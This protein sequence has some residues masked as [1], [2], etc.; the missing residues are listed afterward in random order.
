[1]KYGE[2]NRLLVTCM[3]ATSVL[4]PL[5]LNANASAQATTVKAAM[6]AAQKSTVDNEKLQKQA[7]EATKQP[8]LAKEQAALDQAAQNADQASVSYVD[9]GAYAKLK[10]RSSL[11]LKQHD[12]DFSKFIFLSDA[13]YL[14]DYSKVGYGSITKNTNPAGGPIH[15][16]VDGQDTTFA[17]GMGVHANGTLVY[18]ISQYH[19]DYPN[20][21]VYAGIDYS[22]KGTN[23][24]GVIFSV[25]GSNDLNGPW[26]E[27]KKTQKLM[28]T[29]NAVR[30][31]ANISGYKYLKFETDKVGNDYND[32]AVFGDL[33]LVKDNYDV[34]QEKGYTGLMTVAQYDEILSQKSPEYN[35]EHNR[36]LILQRELVNR[37][38]Y[39]NIQALSKTV[40]G[41]TQALDWLKSDPASLQLLIEA[42]NFFNGNGYNATVALGRLYKAHKDDLGDSG[43]KLVYKKMMLAT[44]AAYSKN[45]KTFLVNYG[46]NAEIS[47]PVVKYEKFKWLYDNGRFVR[48]DEF[49]NYPME[50]VRYVMDAKMDDS[51]II[52]LSDK[53]EKDMPNRND[54]QRLSGYHYVRYVNTGYGKKEFYAPEYKEQWDKKYL[55]TQHG[56]S[57][58][59]PNLY[60]LWMLMEAGGI[61]WGIS[62]IGMN[63]AEVQGIPS[64]NTY[65]PQHEAYLIYKQNNQGKG[66]WEI[67][68]NIFG[69]KSSYSRWGNTAETQARLL[70]GWGCMDFNRL[71]NSNN[72]T[73]ILLAQAALN[74]YA[75]YKES[76][77]YS[78]LANSY[79]AGSKQQN[80]AYNKSLDKLAINLDSL[81]GLIKSY[82]ANPQ[83]T[84]EEW[85]ALAKKIVAAYTYYP[86]P[87]VDLLALIAQHLTNDTY[88]TEVDILKQNAL[89]QASQATNEQS[90]QADACREIAKDLL[91]KTS[92][93]LASFSFDGANAGKIVLNKAYDNYQIMTRVSLD[94]G[95]TWEKFNNNGKTEEYT[96]DHVISLSK[97]QLAKINATNDI[98]V[99]LV[100]TQA[101]SKIDIKDGQ[102]VSGVYLNDDEN[103]L[104]GDTKNLQYST[105][106][107][108]TWA[109]Y[110]GSLTSQTRLTGDVTAQFRRLAQGT[111]LQGPVTEFKFTA[112][113]DPQTSQYV[114]LQA[115]SLAGF[116]SEETKKAQNQATNLLDG[117]GNT[118]WHTKWD[119]QDKEKYYTVELD[120]VRYINKLVYTSTN[121]QNGRLQKGNVYVSLDGKKW[122]K[123][124][125]FEGIG[126]YAGQKVIDLGKDYPAKYVKLEA[127]GTYGMNGQANW[128]FSGAMLSLYENATKVYQ[129]KPTITYSSSTLTNQDVTAK[130]VLPEGCQASVTSH[131]FTQNGDYTFEYQDLAG[132]TQTIQA[133]V[134]WIDKK[135]PTP[136]V[137]YSTTAPTNGNVVATITGF[138]E[139]GVKVLSDGGLTHEFDKNG[140]FTFKFVDQAGNQGTYVAKVNNI[141]KQAPVLGVEFDKANLTNT[142]VKATLV[143]LEAGDEIL[144]DGQKQHVFTQ[145]G[146]WT[147]KVKDQAGNV[148]ELPV[149][150]DWIDKVKPT[151]KISYSEQNWTSKNVTAQLS[152]LSEDVTFL[153]NTQGQYIFEDNGKHE[154]V[155]K[156]QAGNVS[157]YEAKVDWIDQTKPSD[158]KMVIQTNPTEAKLNVNS[159][160][161]EVLAVNGKK[162]DNN[163]T[164]DKNGTYKFKLKMKATGYTFDY[165]V[166]VD[167][168]QA[169]PSNDYAVVATNKLSQGQDNQTL[170]TTQAKT[171][172]AATT[173]QADKDQAVQKA[174]IASPLQ[175]T[176]A[177]HQHDVVKQAKDERKMVKIAAASVSAVALATSGWVLF[178]RK[179]F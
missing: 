102:K 59:K 83:T 81:Y 70:L 40:D 78:L 54:S 121:G 110:D 151:A 153:D 167:N 30:I 172:V 82:A 140:E 112:N 92:G 69:W 58:G 173:K 114:P 42:G 111:S 4:T 127:T 94:G 150:V 118:V 138:D 107:G 131:T 139:K 26:T 88:K 166:H 109:D 37:L 1:M 171:E 9:S 100:G 21:S 13:P 162:A 52:W 11:A 38:G 84:Q 179:F 141:D 149:K 126:N 99:G 18:D 123:V 75:N 41:V 35:Y 124:K 117:N 152:D 91:G 106:N 144:N 105:D 133:H 98:T 145:N 155:V 14:T 165:T 57:Y 178:K 146:T 43:D 116:S 132:K 20:L 86:A 34:T 159:D 3:L 64:V 80:E 97:E 134:D 12:V 168:L 136:T 142:D 85:L 148:S 120:K 115:L 49:K 62:G 119:T 25:S 177:K 7:G 63:Q 154:F 101:T 31:T 103:L 8:D 157:T 90:L 113:H 164:I 23:T 89:T 19:N 17:K 6:K 87:M 79:Q 72:T 161:I 56:I 46:G 27:I 22:R 61:C 96:P 55:L 60:H 156:D 67:W 170:T 47:D 175:S 36:N 15:L 24:N 76:M 48:K 53:I 71:N 16:L 176:Q 130:L 74:D 95:H 169:K 2:F 143:G 108:K 68:T 147:F 93:D 5:S 39:N 73:Y 163:Y 10:G 66:L 174:D 44:V 51:E 160:A 129:E 77:I 137:T 104:I 29:D 128:Y 125:F 32:H 65:Q 50:L 28:P 122:D 158:D 135:A 45:I 33:R